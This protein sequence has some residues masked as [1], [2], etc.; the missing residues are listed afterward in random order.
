MIASESFTTGDTDFNTQLTKIKGTDAEVIFIPAYYQDVTYITKQASDMGMELPF[1]G[2]D[3][4]DGVLATVSDP[5]TVEGAIFA[6]PFCAAVDDPNV[7]AFV[8]AYEAAY[9]ATPDQFAADAYDAIYTIKA[10]MEQAGSTESEDLIAAMT[11][12]TVN[13]LTGESITFSAEG[14]PNKEIKYVEIKDGQY[15]YVEE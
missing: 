4:W 13:G 7:V 12:I 5:A 8:E 1:I 10:A 6:S 9:S 14:A 2:S 11:E 15:Q 3:G